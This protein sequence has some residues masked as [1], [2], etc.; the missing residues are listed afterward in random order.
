MI[1]PDELAV[2]VS[3]T[4]AAGVPVDSQYLRSEVI[5]VKQTGY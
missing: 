5:E 1:G 4:V 3:G 2:L